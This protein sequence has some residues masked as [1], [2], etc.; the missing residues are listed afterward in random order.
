MPWDDTEVPLREDDMQ[1]RELVAEIVLVAVLL[2]V[3]GMGQAKDDGAGETVAMVQGMV[4]RIHALVMSASTD[5]E[6]REDVRKVLEEVVDFPEFGKLCLGRHWSELKGPQREA[7]LAAFKTLLQ[8]NYL[9]RFK[10]GQEFTVKVNE[11]PR[12]NREGDRAEVSTHLHTTGDDL[13]VE[14]DYRFYRVP[15][16][17]K[18]YDIVVDEVS[19]MRNYRRSFTRVYTRDGFDELLGRMQKRAREIEAGENDSDDI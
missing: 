3:P 10:R 8:N 14:V 17:W 1:K 19:M 12:M 5:E 15:S 7:Y 11:K 9:R 4:Q 18:I 13:T 16:G 2:L 6:M